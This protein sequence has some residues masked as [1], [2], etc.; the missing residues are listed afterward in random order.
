MSLMRR[1]W[2]Y[3]DR[4][5]RIAAIKD[6][7][8]RGLSSKQIADELGCTKNSI[9]GLAD[10]VGIQLVG[11]KAKQPKRPPEKPD[12]SAM[13]AE[14]KAA[15]LRGCYA[16]GITTAEIVG[17]VR[18]A[19]EKAVVRCAERNGI[20]RRVGKSVSA[21]RTPKAKRPAAKPK[22]APRITCEP[23]NILDV[24]LSG[25]CRAPVWADAPKRPL[26]SPEDWMYC[27][28]PTKPGSSYCPECHVRFWVPLKYEQKVTR[29]QMY[30]GYAR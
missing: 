6:G 10:R 23:V 30:G 19:T 8:S 5:Q 7:V 26:R 24:A 18:N 17:M 28:R 20:S 4:D 13:S 9:I 11:G 1:N 29:Q 15:F 2:K 21:V 22:E 16:A 3:L 27:G 12:W 14:H 25:Q